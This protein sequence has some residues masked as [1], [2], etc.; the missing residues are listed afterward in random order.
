M[1][2]AD[3]RSAV[4]TKQTSPNTGGLQ[5]GKR[6][7]FAAQGQLGEAPRH[8]PCHAGT[9][10]P[11]RGGASPASPA[12]APL[13]P[14]PAPLAPIP[15]PLAPPA[16]P[17][18]AAGSQGH[19]AGRA[20]DWLRRHGVLLLSGLIG[21]GGGLQSNRE[22]VLEKVIKSCQRQLSVPGP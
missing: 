21:A 11:G 8:R 10:R 22:K 5:H 14:V 3:R 12:P 6:P 17:P 4:H 7:R 19:R 9:G 15:A 16:G 20:R 13:A 1:N 2:T 18:L